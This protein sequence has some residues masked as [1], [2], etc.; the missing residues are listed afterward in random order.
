MRAIIALAALLSSLL[1]F[2]CLAWLSG[3]GSGSAR[4]WEKKE[5][6]AST[7]GTP[8]VLRSLRLPSA[9]AQ[10]A[11][12]LVTNRMAPNQT[13]IQK[14]EQASKCKEMWNNNWSSSIK[15]KRMTIKKVAE[16]LD[17]NMFQKI[18][19]EIEITKQELRHGKQE[20]KIEFGKMKQEL[21]EIGDFMREEVDEIKDITRQA[22]EEREIKGKMQV[23]EIGTDI[24][25]VEL[26]KD[27][28]FMDLR[29]KDYCLEFSVV[30]EEIDEDI[31]DKAINVS[32]KFLDW[33]DVMELEIEK[34]YRIN[35]R[36]VTME[37]L[38]RDVL[39]HFVKKRNR[40]MTLQQHFSNTFRIDGKEI[41]VRKEIPIRL[42]LYDYD[43]DSKIIMGA[44]MED[45]INTGNG[46]MAIEITG[47]SR[48]DEMD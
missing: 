6:R 9:S 29:D 45:G 38:S 17:V 25:N 13:G 4:S 11:P 44:R 18:M 24:S 35:Y 32:K 42:L 15:K 8:R 40:D 22:I 2:L 37:K 43:Y 41:F 31:R 36:Y 33:N 21:K 19:D 39:V 12:Q 34:I 5:G 16:T 27:L 23:L 46:R 26:E 10:L 14:S 28:E 3:E 1:L 20:M 7:D 48:L 47:P 30:P